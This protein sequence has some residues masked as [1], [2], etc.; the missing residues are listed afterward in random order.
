MMSF[1]CLKNGIHLYFILNFIDLDKICI[2]AT[3]NK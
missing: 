2:F 1:K 3:R